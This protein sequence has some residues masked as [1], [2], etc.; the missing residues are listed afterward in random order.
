MHGQKLTRNEE[1]HSSVKCNETGRGRE[2]RFAVMG[3][4]SAPTRTKRRNPEEVDRAHCHC[5][6]RA[7][8]RPFH[9]VS[10]TIQRKVIGHIA[11]A[12]C[13]CAAKRPFH[14]ISE[15][16]RVCSSCLSC[17]DVTAR[18][19]L[20][21]M[22][23][24]KLREGRLTLQALVLEARRTPGHRWDSIGYT[25]RRETVAELAKN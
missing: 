10:E 15:T 11:S 25:V 5:A 9:L 12:R 6:V 7:A 8:K 24:G 2:L 1:S 20:Y 18:Q 17:R 3:N 23:K 14:L 4:F 16:T 21:N 22:Q 19:N 13:D